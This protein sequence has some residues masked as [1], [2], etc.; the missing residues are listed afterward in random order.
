VSS[1]KANF[2]KHSATK[3][4]VTFIRVCNRLSTSVFRKQVVYLKGHRVYFYNFFSYF[5]NIVIIN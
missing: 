4:I 1:V 5:P 3:V 2:D